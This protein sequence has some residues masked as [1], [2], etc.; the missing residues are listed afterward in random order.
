M[1]RF[2]NPPLQ[3]EGDREAVEGYHPSILSAAPASGT[4]LRRAKARHLPL[5][6]RI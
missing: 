4:P 2:P 3:G 6:G 5:Q 1:I